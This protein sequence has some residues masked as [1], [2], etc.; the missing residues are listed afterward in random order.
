MKQSLKDAMI[1]LAIIVGITILS[2]L[3]DFADIQV[4]NIFM[5][6][7][8]GI[9]MIIIKTKKYT[10]GAI[11]SLI[12]VVLSNYLF[13]S[14]RYTFH[15]ADKNYV[16]SFVIFLVVSMIVTSLTVRIQN[17]MKVLEK[18]QKFTDALYQFSRGYLDVSG[19]SQVALYGIECL[20]TVVP[21]DY[22]ICV[23]D[24]KKQEPLIY[25]EQC[26]GPGEQ[27]EQAVKR[28]IAQGTE[29]G[30]KLDAVCES[31]YRMMPIISKGRSYG[32]LAVENRREPQNE[33]EI[34]MIGA[35]V[36]IIAMAMDREFA[37]AAEQESQ[38]ASE[39]EKLRSSLLRSISHD[40]RTPLAGITGSASFLLESYDQVDAGSRNMLLKDIVDD[41]IWLG[42]LVENLLNTTKIQ[43]GQMRLHYA[44]EVVDDLVSEMNQR[45]QKR[46]DGRSFTIELREECLMVPMDGPLIMSVL[47][48]LM[49]NAIKH[50]A[51]NGTI[52]L[53][54][55]QVTE[56]GKACMRLAVIDD[57]TGIAPDIMERMFDSFVTDGNNGRLESRGGMG[58]GLSIANEIIKAHNGKMGSYNNED[59]GATVYFLLPMEREDAKE[60]G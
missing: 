15:I 29:Y 54:A 30:L 46:L 4:E 51:E 16:V 26:T 43:E 24:P 31:D 55:E 34:Q 38:L 6:Y 44:D 17:Q 33:G 8:F 58:L 5:L 2:F 11:S 10:F 1:T 45:I 14:P 13:V 57:G 40:L 37:K 3:M 59:K 60:D 32:V 47:I 18:T 28:Y 48:N 12:M 7:T 52:R 35:I 20:N 53:R 36:P 23:T 22:V 49:E 50:T 41:S 21:R 39:R 9:L 42:Q 27:M 56:D 25:P 19:V